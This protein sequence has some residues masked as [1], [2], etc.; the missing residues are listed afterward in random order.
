MELE[1]QV[2]DRQFDGF[3]S[4]SHDPV[5]FMYEMYQVDSLSGL[6]VCIPRAH[7]SL[8]SAF[9]AHTRIG[10]EVMRMTAGRGGD[11]YKKITEKYGLL[12]IWHSPEHSNIV[13]L[14]GTAVNRENA[15]ADIAAKMRAHMTN[16]QREYNRLL[17]RRA[18]AATATL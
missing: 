14:G 9:C 15:I 16:K 5:D 12:K 7:S 6:D 11:I 3:A 2:L 8:M 4:M 18:A 1:L 10:E 17:K 13:L